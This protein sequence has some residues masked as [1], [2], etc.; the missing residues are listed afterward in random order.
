MDEWLT[1]EERYEKLLYIAT[2]QKKSLIWDRN[3]VNFRR[4]LEG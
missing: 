1:K 2:I 4:K 3:L